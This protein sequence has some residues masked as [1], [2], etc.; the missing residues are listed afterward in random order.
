MLSIK[1]LILTMCLLLIIDTG[2]LLFFKE[3]EAKKNT[4]KKK[5]INYPEVSSHKRPD[6]I[7]PAL[8]CESCNA[9]LD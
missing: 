5:P 9:I 4:K 1:R 8:Y 3:A 2:S 7:T 6:D